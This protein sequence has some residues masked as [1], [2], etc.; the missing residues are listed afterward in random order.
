[1]SS[2]PVP[3]VGLTEGS[4][5]LERRYCEKTG[6]KLAITVISIGTLKIV[7]ALKTRATQECNI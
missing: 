3:W 6:G 4:S 1:M 5:L 2:N 7:P